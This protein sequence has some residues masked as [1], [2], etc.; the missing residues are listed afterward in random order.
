MT[1]PGTAERPSGSPWR[2][3]SGLSDAQLDE[4]TLLAVTETMRRSTVIFKL[5]GQT[6]QMFAGVAF[7]T[8]WVCAL[9]LMPWVPARILFAAQLV[10]LIPLAV[11]LPL[12]LRRTFDLVR[13]AREQ[14]TA[15]RDL[16]GE[17]EA[18]ARRTAGRLQ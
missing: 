4:E 10:V 5:V 11:A 6:N 2:P 9:A 17:R 13:L 16:Q 1:G 18:R 7:C 15:L 14:E 12:R 3:L 8:G